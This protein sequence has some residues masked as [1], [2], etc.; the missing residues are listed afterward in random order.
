MSVVYAGGRLSGHSQDHGA[1]RVSLL[2]PRLRALQ[3]SEPTPTGAGCEICGHPLHSAL[4][5]CEPQ[6]RMDTHA[7]AVLGH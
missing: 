6:F 3:N 1:V 7:C 2:P 5:A 4:S